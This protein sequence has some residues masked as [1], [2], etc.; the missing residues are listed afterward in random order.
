MHVFEEQ[1]E[2]PAVVHLLAELGQGDVALLLAVG[3]EQEGRDG[4]QVL[5]DILLSLLLRRARSI[6][7]YWRR[8][9][10]QPLSV[11]NV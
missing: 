10:V 8:I 9:I 11:E 6:L 1:K 2:E 5:A 4:H 3:A 7:E